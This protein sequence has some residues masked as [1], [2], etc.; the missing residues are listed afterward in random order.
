MVANEYSQEEESLG[1]TDAGVCTTKLVTLMA[2]EL[3][4]WQAGTN[5]QP[6]G[7]MEK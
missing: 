7:V 2:D 1:P 5:P 4:R 6:G 3:T